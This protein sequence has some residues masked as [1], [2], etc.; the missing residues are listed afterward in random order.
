M[1]NELVKAETFELVTLTGDLAEA[2]A[3][4][5]GHHVQ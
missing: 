3:D 4:C 1:A 5:T 2:I